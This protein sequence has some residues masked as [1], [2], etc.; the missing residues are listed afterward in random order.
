M[1]AIEEAVRRYV[2]VAVITQPVTGRYLT[3]GFEVQR[4]ETLTF[5]D[6]LHNRVCFTARFGQ[7]FDDHSVGRCADIG[8]GLAEFDTQSALIARGARCGSTGC[9]R[10]LLHARV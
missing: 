2:N 3:A 10:G 9:A 1:G 8:G 4:F 5:G 6:V 7:T